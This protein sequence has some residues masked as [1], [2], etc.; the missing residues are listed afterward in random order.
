M[1]GECKPE[2]SKAVLL[3]FKTDKPSQELEDKVVKVRNLSG[4]ILRNN[5]RNLGFVSS[6]KIKGR[7]FILDGY[8]A[9]GK[10][11]LTQSHLMINQ[12]Y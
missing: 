5:L 10:S 9:A 4:L 1:H 7:A 3:E 6:V 2:F 11:K 8:K 12:R